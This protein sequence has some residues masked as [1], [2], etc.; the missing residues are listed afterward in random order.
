M[1]EIIILPL[2]DEVRADALKIHVEA[3][4]RNPEG[5]AW[6]WKYIR[7]LAKAPNLNAQQR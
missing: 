1:N 4:D 6:R 3:M 7:A 5:E 2:T